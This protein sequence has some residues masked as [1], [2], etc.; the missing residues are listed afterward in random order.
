VVHGKRDVCQSGGL[1]SF[2]VT[3]SPPTI[4]GVAYNLDTARCYHTC[5]PPSSRP[6]RHCKSASTGCDLRVGEG[7]GYMGSRKNTLAYTGMPTAVVQAPG[8]LRNPRLM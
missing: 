7:K 6:C 3:L 4:G 5:P 8:R 1:S 2:V